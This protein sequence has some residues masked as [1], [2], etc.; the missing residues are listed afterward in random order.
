MYV[1]MYVCMHLCMYYFEKTE[2][3]QRK[4]RERGRIPSRLH[5]VSTQPD[6]GLEL[7]KL[8]LWPEWKSRAGRFPD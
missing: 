2:C 7:M 1:G 3:E 8:R 6:V 4:G 5:T